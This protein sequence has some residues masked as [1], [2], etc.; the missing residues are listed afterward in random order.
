MHFKMYCDV[1]KGSE[2]KTKA[3]TDGSQGNEDKKKTGL[4]IF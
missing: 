3:L 1:F 4:N 2:E